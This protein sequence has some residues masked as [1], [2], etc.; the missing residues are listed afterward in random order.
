MSGDF[1]RIYPVAGFVPA[2]LW[3][4]R[5]TLICYAIRL[6]GSLP[7]IGQLT[8]EPTEW[9]IE[10]CNGMMMPIRHQ[11]YSTLRL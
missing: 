10:L 3:I 1:V 6:A 5:S 4:W 8:H 9:R 2:L 11:R 7:A